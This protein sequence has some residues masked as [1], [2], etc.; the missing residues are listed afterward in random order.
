MTAEPGP[1]GWRGSFRRPLLRRLRALKWLGRGLL[2]SVQGP[3]RPAP[4]GL[5]GP[6]PLQLV[7]G[8]RPRVRFNPPAIAAALGWPD[9]SGVPRSIRIFREAQ[10]ASTGA[11][12][13][14][15]F[16]RGHHPQS[17]IV[18]VFRP[19]AAGQ[20]P[21]E[22][23]AYTSGL[24]ASLPAPCAAPALHGVTEAG[25][26]SALWLEDLGQQ[27]D[28][29]WRPMSLREYE[30]AGYALGSMGGRFASAPPSAPWLAV[31]TTVEHGR[32][33]L[34]GEA[35]TDRVRPGC[36]LHRRLAQASRRTGAMLEAFAA[37]HPTLCHQDATPRNLALAST[38][39][40]S[41]V[42]LLDWEMCGLGPLGQDLASL[43][44]SLWR[45]AGVSRVLEREA[46]ATRGYLAGIE[47]A[48]GPLSPARRAEIRL[49][50]LVALS[51]RYL[52]EI[53]NV[54]R[55]DTVEAATSR[56]E[57]AAAMVAG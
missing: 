24:L 51:V 44:W 28:R 18:K 27:P 2:R 15:S 39:P 35:W 55:Y 53:V 38:G 52:V 25:G 16:A 49:A 34:L 7:G 50:Y 36:A 14:V 10:G 47:A 23:A 29:L 45:F 30:L 54:A 4:C 8:R 56:F 26:A 12:L 21:R 37:L 31:G 6:A 9:G 46:A 41:R 11:V 32:R 17:A 22:V 19:G 33:W 40:R 57:E 1:R 20:V 42:A 13:R 5:G 48:M 3:T 43:V